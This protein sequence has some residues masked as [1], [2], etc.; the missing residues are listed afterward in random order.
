[1][2]EETKKLNRGAL[3]ADFSPELISADF[4]EP[5]EP[6]PEPQEPPENSVDG[7]ALSAE[8]ITESPYS[9]RSHTKKSGTFVVMAVSAICGAIGGI[10]ISQNS[11]VSAVVSQTLSQS[12]AQ[13]FAAR[14]SVGAALLAVEFVLGFFALGDFFV[15]TVPL[16]SGLGLSLRVA[17][18]KMWSLLPSS[19]IMLGVTAFAAA[20]SAGFSQMLM[21][22]SRGGTV[23]L[24]SSPRRLYVLNF[25]GYLAAIIACALYEG[26]ILN[27]NK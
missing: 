2:P 23:H 4:A 13:V 22:I 10:I 26:I 14:L 17:A 18:E 11:A 5:S 7:Q 20:V 16:I 25:L 1:M 6:D 19:L 15:W 12:F 8:L 3:P 27:V 24:G 9:R 21:S